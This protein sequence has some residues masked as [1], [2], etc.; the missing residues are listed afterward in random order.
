M[1]NMENST[2][3]Y[4][5]GDVDPQQDPSPPNFGLGMC[6]YCLCRYV[7]ILYHIGTWLHL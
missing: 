6:A 3:K 7:V 4:D 5:V 1:K 2:P